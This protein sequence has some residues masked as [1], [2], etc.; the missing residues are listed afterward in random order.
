L[1]HVPIETQ[2]VS[3][4]A[5]PA[6]VSVKRLIFLLTGV[7]PLYAIIAYANP[8]TDIHIVW[9]ANWGIPVAV[10]SLFAI[11]AWYLYFTKPRKTSVFWRG[12]MIE[13][14]PVR[15]GLTGLLVGAL[16]GTIFGYVARDALQ[17][18]GAALSGTSETVFAKVVSSRS[19]GARSRC[20]RYTIFE[21]SDKSSQAVCVIHSWRGDLTSDRLSNGDRVE[22]QVRTNSI[23]QW[24]SR[25]DR[26]PSDSTADH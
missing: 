21:F 26:H 25:V 11:H 8:A 2:G 16:F 3:T 22:L 10:M 18:I 5:T 12:K 1:L 20:Q 6:S 4:T 23:G 7:L 19:T 9:W 24:V 17:V 15:W 13:V 14:G